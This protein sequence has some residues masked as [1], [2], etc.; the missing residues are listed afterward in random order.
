[1]YGGESDTVHEILKELK[2][3]SCNIHIGEVRKDNIHFKVNDFIP[4]EGSYNFLKE[5]KTR[6][7]IKEKILENKK[8]IFYFPYAKHASETYTG[9]NTNVMK[10]VAYYTGKLDHESRIEAQEEFKDNVKKI[11][12][13]TKAFGMGVDIPDIENI[14][15]YGLSGDLSDYVQ[16]IG[17]CAR[18]KDVIGIAEIDF[19]KLDL[20]YPK[21]L[22]SISGVKQWQMKLVIEKLFEL[23]KLNN[24]KSAFLLSIESFSHIFTEK[25]KD[26]EKKV[27]QA[28]GL[29]I[30]TGNVYF[31]NKSFS[32]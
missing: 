28:L 4:G 8:S 25:E 30:I 19:N 13:A 1:I 31:S 3:D 15:H 14:Y 18:N 17:R 29:A 2:I 24:Y 20:K 11:M 26:L 7:K 9:L 16:E 23:Y 10:R 27:K 5:E 6:E 12:L 32:K 21:M 22:R